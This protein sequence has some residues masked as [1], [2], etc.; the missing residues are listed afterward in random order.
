[1]K[2]S[3]YNKV[4]SILHNICASGTLLNEMLFCLIIRLISHLFF[5][6]LFCKI[7]HLPNNNIW[8]LGKNNFDK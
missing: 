1:M 8:Y 5:K 3:L 2:S 4:I 7:I 6:S